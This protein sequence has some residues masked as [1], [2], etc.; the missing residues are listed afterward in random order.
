MHKTQ[1]ASE[2]TPVTQASAAQPPASQYL[3]DHVEWPTVLLALV[4][5]GMWGT[6]L[7]IGSGAVLPPTV[8]GWVQWTWV[9]LAAIATAWQASLQHEVIHGHPT[10]LPWLNRIIAGPP[11]LVWLPYSFYRRSHLAHHRDEMLTDPFNDPESF[12]VSRAEWRRASRPR[13]RLLIAL[14]TLVGRLLLGP[15]IYATRALIN[16]CMEHVKGETIFNR[17]MRI[18]AL[19]SQG[20]IVLFCIHAAG[21][22]PVAYIVFV[23][24]PAT[25]LLLLRSFAEHR[26]AHAA[27]HRSVIVEA[28]GIFDL[29]FLSNNLHALHHERPGL[30]WYALR[31]AYTARRNEVLERNGGYIFRDYK[32]V[33]VEYAFMPRDHPAHRRGYR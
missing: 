28:R 29:L 30:A 12:Y 10:S 17:L 3:P 7:L 25:S 31:K 20:L 19:I 22:N 23:I 9:P 26:V 15:P 32:E 11:L 6:A 14:N 2:L 4:I 27:E 1:D 13:R 8:S 18:N 33:L 16:S 21:I 5:Y 24:Y